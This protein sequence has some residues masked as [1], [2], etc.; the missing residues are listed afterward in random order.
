MTKT[1]GLLNC[2]DYNEE[3]VYQSVKKLVELVPPPNVNGKVVL[4]KPNILY[5]KKPEMAVCTHPVVVGAAVKVFL[6]LGAK[7]VIVGESPA[8]NSSISSAKITGMYD[9]VV[10]NGGEWADFHERVSVSYPEGK[11]VKQFEFAKQF[12]EADIL[13]SLSKLKSHQ[14]MRYTGAMKNLFGLMVGLDKAQQHYRFSEKKS[15][16]TFLTDLVLAANPDY[17][18]MDAIVGMDGPGGPV[19]GDTINLGFLAASD[20]LLA[21]DW[22]CAS[23]V[24]YNPHNVLNLEDALQ[25]GVWLS[26]P[27]EITTVGASEDSCRCSTFKIVKDPSDK[28]GGMVPGFLD[29]L[30]NK[31]FTKTPKINSTKCKKCQKCFEICPAHIISM[32]G[33][34]GT[35]KVTSKSRCLHCYCCHEICS[36]GAIKLK[37]L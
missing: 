29:K 15:F 11:L 34:G 36:F 6:E 27:D 8:V 9:Q 23:F 12:E 14:L 7:K 17:A 26:S 16:A 10:K 28:I 22:K 13:V 33:K 24:G 18:I 3:K 31:V 30:A 20:N 32:T 21:L 1:V 5:P 4:L 19:G 35:A 2:K 37:R 25:R